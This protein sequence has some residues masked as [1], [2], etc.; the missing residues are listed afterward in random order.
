M[1]DRRAI[2]RHRV[3]LGGK[4]LFP[5][6][7][8]VVDC[9]VVNMTEDGARIELPS[10]VDVRDRVYLWEFHTNMVFNPRWH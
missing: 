5:D 9:R 1:H 2:A 8:C 4:L 7:S 6:A 10:G 3:D